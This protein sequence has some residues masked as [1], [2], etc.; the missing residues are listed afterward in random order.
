MLVC[1]RKDGV[2]PLPDGRRNAHRNGSDRALRPAADK[3]TPWLSAHGIACELIEPERTS[4][5]PPYEHVSPQAPIAECSVNASSAQLDGAGWL[6]APVGRGRLVWRCERASSQGVADALVQLLKSEAAEEATL[7]GL[8]PA[9]RARRYRDGDRLL[10]HALPSHVTTMLH[11]TLVNQISA[12]RIVE[13]VTYQ[14]LTDA[15][16]VSPY[17]RFSRVTLHSPD[18]SAPRDAEQN[19]DGRWSVDPAGVSRYLIL[20]CCG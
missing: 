3:A 11:P 7:H 10:I 18:L 2:R 6:T 15:I 12:E 9:W 13:G 16:A 17:H 20:E 14:G 4:G 5:F 1:G 8:P 19:A